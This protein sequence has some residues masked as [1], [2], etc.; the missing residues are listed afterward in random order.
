ME[1]VMTIVSLLLGWLGGWVVNYL[2]D[3]LPTTRSFSQPVCQRCQNA[4]RFMDYLLLQKCVYCGAPRPVR[5]WAVQIMMPILSLLLWLFP[6]PLLPYPLGLVTVLYFSLVAITDLEYRVIL[7]PVS[8]FGALLGLGTGLYLRS[9]ESF[10]QGLSTTLIGGAVGFGIMFIFYLLGEAY[11]RRMAK[12]KNL[13]PDEVALGFGDVNLGGI[14]GLFVGWP[15]ILA[16]LFFAILAGGAASLLIILSMLLTK[17]Y[18][19][20]LAIPYAP[21]LIFGALYLLFLA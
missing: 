18:R 7:H 19:A 17:Q 20:F 1:V 9:H 3:V 21:F 5:A 8:L 4:Y 15:A 14:I 2:A 16:G 6:G 11:V 10:G 13:P 12:K